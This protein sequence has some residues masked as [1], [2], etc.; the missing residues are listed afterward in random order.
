MNAFKKVFGFIWQRIALPELTALLPIVIPVVAGLAGE[1]IPGQ[2]KKKLA[3]S[4]I[5]EE[6]K[7]RKQS[8]TDRAINLA[9]ELA[10]T[11]NQR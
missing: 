3:L 5:R 10:L 9:I 6:L 2:T 8:A 4:R 7:A 11:R 1:R